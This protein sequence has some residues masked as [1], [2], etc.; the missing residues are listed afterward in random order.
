[1]LTFIVGLSIAA[2]LLLLP[3][4]LVAVFLRV[5]TGAPRGS[6]VARPAR[7]TGLQAQPF[8]TAVPGSSSGGRKVS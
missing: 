8:L 7:R 6:T 3:A 1:M 5:V 2:A 4:V